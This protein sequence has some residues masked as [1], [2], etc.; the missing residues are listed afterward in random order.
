MVFT[1]DGIYRYT[2]SKMYMKYFIVH[3]MILKTRA[4]AMRHSAT[5]FMIDS[6]LKSCI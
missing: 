1:V 2:Y 5:L 6:P 4:E 3:S